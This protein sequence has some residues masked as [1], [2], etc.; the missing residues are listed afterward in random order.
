MT[1]AAA[2]EWMLEQVRENGMLEQEF[3]V[4]AIHRQFGDQF[5]YIN[6]NGNLAIAKPVTFW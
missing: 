5:T 2:A 4:Y 3:A 6:E 1:A